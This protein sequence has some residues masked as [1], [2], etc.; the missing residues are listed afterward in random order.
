ML[1]SISRPTTGSLTKKLRVPQHPSRLS[2]NGGLGGLV[3]S[4]T[5]CKALSD[6]ASNILSDIKGAVGSVRVDLVCMPCTLCG[7][8]CSLGLLKK[9]MK[10]D[11]IKYQQFSKNI[12]QENEKM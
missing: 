1:L 4:D 3:N 5:L 9:M 8:A 2:L 10:S 12:V 11:Q 6:L 7:S